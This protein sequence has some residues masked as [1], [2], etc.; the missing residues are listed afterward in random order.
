LLKALSEN[1]GEGCRVWG[2]LS[3]PKVGGNFHIAPGVPSTQSNSHCTY[4]F[5]ASIFYP[6]IKA[7]SF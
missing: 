4:S 1:P 3:V 7:S 2:K 5:F 6:N